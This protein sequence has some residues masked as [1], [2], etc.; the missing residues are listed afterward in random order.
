MTPHGY[1]KVMINYKVLHAHRVM[2][3][4]PKGTVV[5]HT[6]DN[7]LCVNPDH[8]KITNTWGNIL[9]KM[10]K[11]RA[12]GRFSGITHC[13]HGHE[14]TPNNLTKFGRCR[15]CQDKRNREYRERLGKPTVEKGSRI[16]EK[17]SG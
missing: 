8:L 7:P 14:R 12:R 3:D 10:N 11:G 15:P 17:E 9:D 5:M 13:P 16:L 4:A 6:C 2:V 1:G